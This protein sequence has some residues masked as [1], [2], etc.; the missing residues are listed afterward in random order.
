MYM[1]NHRY[2]YIYIYAYICIVYTSNWNKELPSHR[3]MQYCFQHDTRMIIVYIYIYMY[4]HI[5][6][7]IHIFIQGSL[8]EHCH[9]QCHDF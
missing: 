1:Y 3:N 7:Y 5:S 6:M 9:H 4:I 8:S 2:T